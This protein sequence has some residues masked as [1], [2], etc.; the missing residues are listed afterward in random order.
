MSVLQEDMDASMSV[1]ILRVHLD[2]NA[3][4]DMK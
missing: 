1:S 3:T 2:V 4:Q